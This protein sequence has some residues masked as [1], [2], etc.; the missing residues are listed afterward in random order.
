MND[1]PPLP[2]P[3]RLQELLFDAA[4]MGRDDV[5]PALLRAGADIE[6]LDARNHSPLI[7]ASYNGQES[8]TALL[9]AEGARPDSETGNSALMGVAFKG[10]AAIAR[11]LIAGGANVDYR[12]GAGQ[13][14]MM[15]AVLFNRTEILDLLIAAGADPHGRDAAG[16]TLASLAE[17]QGNDALAARFA[18]SAGVDAAR[19]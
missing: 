4:R 11:T 14:A 1:L 6:G 19:L 10:Y 15:M 12:N 8:T 2:S 3:E 13:N 18:E 16:N 5:I 17:A 7:L 9:L